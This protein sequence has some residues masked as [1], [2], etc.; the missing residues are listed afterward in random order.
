MIEGAERESER[1]KTIA[2]YTRVDANKNNHATR[3]S[4][5]M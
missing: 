4:R 1:V 5:R 2:N 3:I